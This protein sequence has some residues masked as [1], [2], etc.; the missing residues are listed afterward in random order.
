[1]QPFLYKKST[2]EEIPL[3]QKTLT[4]LEFHRIKEE[5][6]RFALTD[7][8]QNSIKNLTP[9]QNLSQIRSWLDEVTEAVAIMKKSSSVPVSGLNGIETIL[10]MLN[11]GVSLRPE[12]FRK[13][14]DFLLSCTKIKRFMKDKE[15]IAPRVA[16]YV[17]VIEE[18][19]ALLEEIERCIRNGGVDDYASKELSK[20]RKQI[21]ILDDRLKEKVYQFVRSAKY[22]SYLQDAIVSERNGRYVI[23]VKKEYKGK[24]K[25]V[26]LDTSASGSTIYVE[27]DE[28]IPY[29]EQIQLLKS[30]EELEVEKI[31]VYLT[32]LVEGKQESLR[33][34]VE[35][36]I[37]YDILFAKAK[38]SLSIDGR[39]VEVNDTHYIHLKQAKHPLLGPEA[40]PLNLEIGKDYHALV[41]TGPNTGGK[42]VGIKTVGLLTLMVQSGLHIPVAE[43]SHIGV[44]QHILVDI[45]D[46]QSIEQNLS[47]FSS[48]IKNIISILQDANDHSLVI[49]DELGSGTDPAEGMGLATA[50]LQQF[51]RKGATILATTHYSEIKEFADQTEGFVNGSMEFDLET[52]KPTYRLIIG[53]GGD[54]QAFAIALKLGIHPNIIQEAYRITYKEDKVFEFEETDPGKIRE[55]EQQVALNRYA[56]RNRKDRQPKGNSKAGFN[57]GDNVVITSTGEF[58]II[59][60]GPDGAGNYSV[61]VQGEKRTYNHKRLKLYISAEELYPADYDFDIIF[62]TKGNRKTKALMEKGHIEG[63]VIDRESQE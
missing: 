24:I 23:P 15:F 10:T 51:Y 39:G 35:T 1:L 28:V 4:V 18:L 42:T 54:S 29:Q 6:S 33:L 41:I 55:M 8:G 11:K 37:H 22:K 49:L 57:Q 26:V 13:L 58:G 38:Y 52:L 31:L 56:R 3:N 2:L 25:G 63:V 27:P 53:K 59:Y 16:S 34:S 30:A 44:F 32:G 61:Q 36:M 62:E 12:H 45:G 9:S 60:K 40:V 19:P 20:I 48:H 50:L 46:G 5:A 7:S 47:T 43:G 21:S 14:A 17:Y